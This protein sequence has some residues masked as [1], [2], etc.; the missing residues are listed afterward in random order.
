L[1]PKPLDFETGKATNFQLTSVNESN[2]DVTIRLTA[3]GVGNHTYTLRTDNLN[4]T[5]PTK[6]IT[7]A[8]GKP[9]TMEWK[10][11]KRI[12]KDTPWVAVAIQDN[13]IK[14][15]KELYAK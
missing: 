10:A 1:L 7:L 5:Q 6:T 9:T 12:N 2:G 11:S 8:E 15:R 4:V 3:T 14:S 13:N